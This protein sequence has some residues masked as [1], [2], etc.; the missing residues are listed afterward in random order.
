[1]GLAS[2]RLAELWDGATGKA[3]RAKIPGPMAEGARAMEK[4]IGVGPG[5]VERLTGV[6]DGFNV[7]FAVVRT[8]KPYDKAKVLGAL[9]PKG[10]AAPETYKG[11]KLYTEGNVALVLL[12]DRTFAFGPE[13]Q[14]KAAL[15]ATVEAGKGKAKGGEG[16]DRA[17]H[18]AAKNHSL[19]A[20]LNGPATVRQI[21]GMDLPEEVGTFRPLLKARDVLL[22]ADLGKRNRAVLEVT[23]PNAKAAQE[24]QK[25]LEVLRKLALR[26]LGQMAKEVKKDEKAKE[27]A[28]LLGLVEASVKGAAI[29]RTDAALAVSA[30]VKVGPGDLA[31]MALQTV[32]K[33]REAAARTQSANNLKQITLAM[34][35]Y[36]DSTGAF[37]PSAIYDKDGKPSLSWRVLILPY[38]EQDGLYRKFKLNEAWDSPH[39]IKLLKFMPKVYATPAARTPHG[40]TH[41]RVFVGNGAAFEGK[42]GMRIPDFTDG[43]SNTILV[44]EADEAVPWTKPEE[45]PY[46][47][48]KP[49]PKLGSIYRNGFLAALADG[50]VR[51]ISKSITEKTLRAAITRNGGEVLGDDF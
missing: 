40:S 38:I 44:V 15:A 23:F 32:Q 36:H 16:L 28:T 41:Y 50:S 46:D 45:L 20:A 27:A 29:K 14:V 24:G 43:T 22:T 51:T 30:E 39:N 34:H 2:V 19:V 37:P 47:P 7:G 49:L 35:N 25:A 48:K 11:R 10:K 21:P 18:L 13:L 5:Q 1:M 4:A 42:R 9:A 3:V 12:D 6:L 17:R 26:S 33:V 31:L 8:V